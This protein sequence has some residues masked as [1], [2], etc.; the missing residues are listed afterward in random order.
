MQEW[1]NLER[2]T[3]VIENT[4]WDVIIY[5]PY[6]IFELFLFVKYYSNCF[7]AKPCIF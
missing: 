7:T 6:E 2:K 4:S 3:N 1:K 5:V